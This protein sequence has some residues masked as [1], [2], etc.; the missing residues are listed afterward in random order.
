M[1]PAQPPA[2]E[3]RSRTVSAGPAGTERVR[4]AAAAAHLEV[5]IFA[6]RPAGSLPEAAAVLRHQDRGHREIPGA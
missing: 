1:Q 4:A 5:E 2:E 6:R 3:G